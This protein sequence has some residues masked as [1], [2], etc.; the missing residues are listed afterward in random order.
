MVWG[1]GGFWGGLQE[2]R[3]GLLFGCAVHGVLALAELHKPEQHGPKRMPQA[4]VSGSWC[5][6]RTRAERCPPMASQQ[7]TWVT[8]HSRYALF[9][10]EEPS[11][12]EQIAGENAI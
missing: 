4:G 1:C 6:L 3:A 11:T 5:Q 7:E 2:H 10:C 12:I 8:I 9:G